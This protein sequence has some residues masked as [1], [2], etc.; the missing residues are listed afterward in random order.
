MIKE[1]Y[2]LWSDSY[3]SDDNPTRD[4]DHLVVSQTIHYFKNKKIIEIGCGTGKNTVLLSKVASQVQAIDFS[5]GMLERAKNKLRDKNNIRFF[6][7][8]I[9][10]KWPFTNG[11]NDV[12][13][14][15]LV[16]EHIEN[17][18]FIFSKAN[19]VLVASGEFFIN[20][21]HPYCQYQ[22]KKPNFQKNGNKIVIESYI[23]DITEFINSGL[24]NNFEL[25]NLNECRENKRDLFPRLISIILKKKN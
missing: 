16:L 24:N 4:L 7:A 17:L 22:G 18:D 15:S 11:S 12:I 6:S 25:R 23:H 5:E 10:K 2:N 8:D 21:F 19:R 1:K 20:E 3:D 9:T 13:L 14:C